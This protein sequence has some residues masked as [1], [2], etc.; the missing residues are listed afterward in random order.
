MEKL[1]ILP[2]NQAGFKRGRATIDNIFVLNRLI[3]KEKGLGNKK[4]KVYALFVDLKAAFDNVER[5]QLWKIMKEKGISEDLIWRLGRVYEDTEVAVRAKDG[6]TDKFRTTKEVRQ[7]CVMSPLLFNIY[8]ADI[9]KALEERNVG[10]IAL[11]KD[12]IWS[13][14]YADDMVFLAKNREALLDMMDII[15]RFFRT[16]KLR[17]CTEKTKVLVFNKGKN[18]KREMWKWEGKKIEETKVFKYLGFVFNSKI[19]NS[20]SNYKEHIKELCNK[21]RMAANKTWGLGKRIC[22]DDFRRRWILFRYLV[23]SNILWGGNMGMG[24]KE[25]T[26]ENNDELCEIDI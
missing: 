16:R 3:Q 11:G 6:L 15:G 18:E 14:E 26:R 4:G 21:D 7:G 17:V 25:G 9:N 10:S 5:E 12:R 19:F 22:R 23:Q 8:I 13:L 20:K 2:E 1:K 24:R